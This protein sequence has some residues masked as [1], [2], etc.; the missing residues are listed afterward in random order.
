MRIHHY[1]FIVSVVRILTGRRRGRNLDPILARTRPPI[2]RDVSQALVFV[3]NRIGSLDDLRRQQAEALDAVGG[4][5]GGR[6]V[7]V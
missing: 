4:G 7:G 2:L 6:A 1:T 5:E 3:R